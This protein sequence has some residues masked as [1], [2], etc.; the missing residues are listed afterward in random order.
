MT[1]TEPLCGPVLHG[2]LL[3]GDADAVASAYID[4][5]G[6]RLLADCRISA[7]HAGAWQ[8]PALA[9]QRMLLLA[10]ASG[11]SEWLRIIEAPGCAAPQPLRH[12]GWMALEVNVQDVDAL[13]ERLRQPGSPFTIIG[14]PAF[15][16]ISDKIR[17][18]QVAGPA[19]EVLYLTEVRAP[20]PLFDLPLSP[21]DPVDRLF[22]PVLSTAQRAASL[23]LHERLAGK[24]GLVLDTRVTVLNR[25]FGHPIERQY[26]IAVLQLAGQA[27][28]E[29]DQ[30][31]DATAQPLQ[32]CGL[33]AGIAMISMAIAPGRLAA[34]GIEGSTLAAPA[35]GARRMA[36]LRGAGGELIELIETP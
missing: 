36:L 35:H 28:L 22:I 31:D 33:P 2:T 13:A 15:L 3:A 14:E 27:L 30:V 16:E 34:L 11:A 6:F 17:A 4:C 19:G 24:S 1:N 23:A 32:A 18:M 20:V 5:F 10:T 9:G 26:P 29:I 12:H 7:E 8:L 25:A 21:V